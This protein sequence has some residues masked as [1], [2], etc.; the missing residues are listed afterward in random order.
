MLLEGQA[1]AIEFE[2]LLYLYYTK[3]HIGINSV[4]EQIEFSAHMVG[5]YLTRRPRI[6]LHNQS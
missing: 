6:K 3:V 2:V 4:K 5:E 1:N